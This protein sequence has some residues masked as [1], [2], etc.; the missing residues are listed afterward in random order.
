MSLID[1]D[2]LLSVFPHCSITR[3]QAVKVRSIGSS[4]HEC[5]EYATFD[6][7]IPGKDYEVRKLA[8]ISRGARIVK[9]LKAHMLIGM[10]I[11]GPKGIVI[12]PVY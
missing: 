11:V 12:D 3:T 1:P 4:I 7:F 2:F 5:C 10:D 6:L 8:K 9:D